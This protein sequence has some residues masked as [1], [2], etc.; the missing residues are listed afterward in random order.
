MPLGEL[1]PHPR[2]P[3]EHPKQGSPLWEVMKRSLQFDYFDPI[4]WNSRNGFLV[5]GHLRVKLLLELGYTHADVSVVDYD[6]PT[7]YAR[8]ISANRPLGEWEETI[9]ASLA[10]DIEAAG[11]DAA[12]AGF[13]HK[14]LCALLDPP[15]V[16][17]DDEAAAEMVTKADELQKKWMVEPGD[18]FQIGPHR[19][20]CGDCA[21]LDNWQRLLEGGQADMIWC[22]PPYNV[23]Y[24][25][26]QRKRNKLKAEGGEVSHVK[27]QT[28]LNDDLPREEYLELLNAWLSAGIAM[29]KQGGSCYIAHADSFGMETRSAARDAGIYVAQC[30]IWVKQ[31]WTLGRQDY[32]WQHEP[33]LY[34]WKPGVGHYWQGGFSQATIIDQAV[35]LKKMSKSELI[36]LVNHMRNSTDTTVI[37]E[38]RNVISDLH[39]TVKPVR[40]VSR[41]IWNSSKRGETV[42]E[43]FGGSGTTLVASHQLGRRCVATELDPKY[44][45]VILE[46]LTSLGLQST[47]LHGPE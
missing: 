10:G 7:H 40:L 2:N 8:M 21:S 37:R 30:L 45:A 38:P 39:P 22:D 19:L 11:L 13:D 47:K 23:A 46:R 17:E 25:Q 4:I 42:L 1:K 12:L 6:E 26:L 20:L 14:S 36:T 18:L 28:I 15:E 27:P 34:G 3:R 43:L 16:D 32:Q 41:H 44:C 5:G 31:A 29:L 35:D 33:I 24:D 9:L